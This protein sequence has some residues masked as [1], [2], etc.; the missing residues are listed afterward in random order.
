[1]THMDSKR[2]QLPRWSASLAEFLV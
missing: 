1:M 2:V